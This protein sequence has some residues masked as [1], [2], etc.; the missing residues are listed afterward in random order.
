M[1]VRRSCRTAR[2]HLL[3]VDVTWI[4][5]DCGG[6]LLLQ[7]SSGDEARSAIRGVKGIDHHN[8]ADRR[9]SV[10][11]MFDV[12]VQAFR[13]C[14]GVER[15][16]A[17]AAELEWS[18]DHLTASGQQRRIDVNG[19]ELPSPIDEVVDA[20]RRHRFAHVHGGRIR[21]CYGA[22]ISAR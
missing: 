5:H 13:R 22:I 7:M 16:A 12:D 3:V 8:A 4:V 14:I 1:L 10:G 19:V 20:G 11:S 17:H 21:S 6:L 2:N 15:A 9:P 18:A